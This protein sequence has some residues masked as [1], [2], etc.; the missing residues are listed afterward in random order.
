MRRI[1]HYYIEDDGVYLHADDLE[2]SLLA[3][4]ES[5]ERT[6]GSDA[7]YINAVRAAANAIG[8]HRDKALAVYQPV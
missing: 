8:Q 3:A 2:A 1:R 4:A 5:L 6:P 7:K